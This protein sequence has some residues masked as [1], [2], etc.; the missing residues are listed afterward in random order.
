MKIRIFL[1][2]LQA[3]IKMV[4]AVLNDY[5]QN[6]DKDADGVPLSP[7]YERFSYVNS[8]LQDLYNELNVLPYEE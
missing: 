5:E 2:L 8:T 1:I 6:G 4:I 7:D 3:L